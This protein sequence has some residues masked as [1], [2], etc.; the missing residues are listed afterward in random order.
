MWIPC[1]KVGNHGNETHLVLESQIWDFL[2]DLSVP[3]T[4]RLDWEDKDNWRIQ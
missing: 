1:S 3:T 2:T 4:Q